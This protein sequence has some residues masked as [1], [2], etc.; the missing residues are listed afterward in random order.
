VVGVGRLLSRCT[1]IE[2]IWLFDVKTC[3]RFEDTNR[4]GLLETITRKKM[5]I[6]GL[7]AS[8][9]LSTFDGLQHEPLCISRRQQQLY[10]ADCNCRNERE[11]HDK[12]DMGEMLVQIGAILVGVGLLILHGWL[13]LFDSLNTDKYE[14]TADE[15]SCRLVLICVGVCV[16]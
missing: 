4:Y 5:S 2:I 9:T 13:N 14:T 8:T 11:Q 16:V 3:Y 12:R 7:S 1:L 15:H 6:S 10:C